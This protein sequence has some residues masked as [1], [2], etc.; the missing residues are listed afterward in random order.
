MKKNILLIG[1]SSGIGKALLTQQSKINNCINFSRTQPELDNNFIHHSIDVTI[2]SF[3]DIENLDCIIYCPGT[4]NLKPISSLKIEDFEQDFKV[5]VL[6]AVRII[7][8]YL[9]I[10]KQGNDPNILMF[11]TV[12]V[13]QGMPFHSSVSVSKGGV[14]GLVKSLAAEL[15]PHVR[16]NCIAP[17][18]TNTP[19]AA[20]ILRN[21]KS[22]E[23]LANKHP[24]KRILNPED[25]ADLASYL[26]SPK[27]K[28]ITGQI[29]S[30]DAGMS[31]LK[32]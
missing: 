15:A 14:E 27:S 29:F 22:I 6:G 7:Q 13:K 4:I 11:S 20:K 19:L 17:T 32:I 5:N 1:G 12:A 8:A 3:P 25:V 16:V 24:L 30:V 26:I 23:N 28:S 31:T 18:I 10:L 21:E 2:D 9:K